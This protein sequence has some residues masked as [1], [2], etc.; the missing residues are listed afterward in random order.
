MKGEAG[1]DTMDGGTGDDYMKGGSGDD[2][3]VGGD[4]DDTL[5]GEDGADTLS[6][7]DGA[8]NLLG[9]DGWD[10]LYG[11]SGWDALY[12]GAGNDVLEGGAG[13]D[14]L[15][16]GEGADTF[17][18]SL[19]EGWDTVKD[20]SMDDLLTFDGDGDLT[21]T[22]DG[23]DVVI[24]FGADSGEET[25]VTVEDTNIDDLRVNESE[26]GGYS[27]TSDPNADGNPIDTF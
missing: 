8:D 5:K 12:G 14:T 25:K 6:G 24:T 23:D 7:G 21:A 17:E 2:T 13:N 3:M 10:E 9:G 16:G 11:D 1:G 4:G 26:G 15:T 20:L 22:Q 27:V 19:D 18:F